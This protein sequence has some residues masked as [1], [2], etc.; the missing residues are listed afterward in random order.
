[1]TDLTGH[2]RPRGARHRGQPRHRPRH[3]RRAAHPRSVGH[4]HRPQA[5]RAARPRRRSWWR[6]RR[7]ARRTGCSPSRGT[8]GR[9]RPARSRWTR[10]VEAF[11]RLDILV[12]NTGVNPTYGPLVDADL[13][14]R[15]QDLRDQRR[16]DARLRAAGLPGVDGRARR[17]DRQPRVGRRAALHRG[18]RG[19]R[20]VQG[21]AHPAHRGAG[22]AA[23]PVDPGQRRGARGREDQV[24]GRA[25]RRGRGQGQRGLP[26]EAA[27]APEDVAALVGFLVSDEASWITGETVRVDGGIL[28]TGTLGCDCERNGVVQHAFPRH[29]AGASVQRRPERP[30]STSSS[31]VAWPSVSEAT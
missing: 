28:A 23:G 2:S 8:P 26:D 12:N 13:D 29:G 17:R 20:R 18:D 30:V 15:P 24:R 16:G 3:R 7:A 6:A 5:R 25:L 27:R 22:L 11:G 31:A 19:L 4:D 1:M 9:P 14:A 21:G 10:T